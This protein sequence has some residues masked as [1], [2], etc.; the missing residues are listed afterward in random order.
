MC[1]G[2]VLAGGTGSRLRPLT[3]VTNKHLLPVYDWPMIFYP[4]NTLK[5]LGITDICV[6]VGGNSVG[7]VLN[8][9]GDGSRFGVRLTYKHQS[10]AGGI[11]QALELT[12]DFV[13]SD[14]V[15]VILGDNVFLQAP[16]GFADGDSTPCVVTTRVQ[17]PEDFG[18]VV[19]GG[20][21]SGEVPY[22]SEIVEKPA[23]PPSNSIVTG[24]YHYPNDVF[25]MIE[26]LK[27]SDRGELEITDVN[28]MMIERYGGLSYAEVEEGSWLDAGSV[29]SIFLA[30][31]S[32]REGKIF[33]EF[34]SSI[35]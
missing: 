27:P 11:A 20:L 32:V 19:W 22:I 4:I 34:R 21:E 28:N 15:T 33:H 7:D 3:E 25:C 5:L 17:N 31:S 12:R 9:L 16:D 30:T 29:D 23:S 1:K 13:G 6:V 18:C 26:K 8:L 24:L 10:S 2:V 14:S 35:G